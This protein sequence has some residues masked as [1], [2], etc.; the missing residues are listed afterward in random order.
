MISE[1]DI[2]TFNSSTKGEENR[3]FNHY[4]E[5]LSI[6]G[7][8][9]QREGLQKTPERVGK[10]MQFL[11]K[12]YKEDPE[13][14]LSSALFSREDSKIVLVKDIDF[15]SLCEHHLL[16]FFGKVS[17]GYIPNRYITGLSKISRVVEV[18]ARRLQ[19]QERLT[20]QIA[21]SIQEVLQ[22]QGVIVRIEA[23]HICME[24]RGVEKVNSH[25]T[26]LDY[27]GC[28]NNLSIREEFFA[29][30]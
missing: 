13:K 7:E 30:L 3:L 6:L 5:I 25:T 14:I 23:R 8:D 24:M 12:G 26:T 15:F 17:V 22:P 21:Q 27:T 11:T 29:L 19:I 16:P 28:F 2:D 1:D 20:H 9:P 18:F 10:M 4:R